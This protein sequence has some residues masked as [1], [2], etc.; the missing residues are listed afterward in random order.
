MYFWRHE[1]MFKK[2]F[3]FHACIQRKGI[4]AEKIDS[5]TMSPKPEKDSEGVNTITVT[6]N[7]M[8]LLK[9]ASHDTVSESAVPLTFFFPSTHS[10]AINFTSLSIPK[11]PSF[12]AT[13]WF[14]TSRFL[15]ISSSCS[16]QYE[17]QFRNLC[18]S[19]IVNSDLALKR[20][21]KIYLNKLSLTAATITHASKQT[22]CHVISITLAESIQ[23]T[24]NCSNIQP[25]YFLA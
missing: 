21:K 23:I 17:R 11:S 14:V 24:H 9:T 1:K 7:R 2:Q 18:I 8:P 10:H 22:C 5:R 15:F 12:H 13:A 16:S 6:G 20:Q 25:F 4:C 19:W 3:V